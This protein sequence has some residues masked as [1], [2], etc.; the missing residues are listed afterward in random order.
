MDG[1]NAEG[2]VVIVGGSGFIGRY[3]VQELAR[4]GVRMRIVARNVPVAQFVK[5]LGGLGQIDIVARDVRDP[6]SLAVAMRGATAAVNLVGILDGTPAQFDAVHARGAG[7]VAHAARAAGAD[8]F[9]QMSA[10]GADAASPAAYARSKAAGEVAVR[11]AFPSATVL[12]PS[13]V[14]G[15]EDAFLNRFAGM[16]RSMPF[17][18][19]VV[20]GRTRFQP[21]YVGDIAQAVAAALTDPATFGGHTYELGGP[22]VYSFRELLA[23][24]VREVRADKPLVDVPDAVAALMARMSGALPG[25][26]M[27]QDQWL[28]LQS[29]NVAHGDG[30][31]AFGI[32]ATPMEAIAPAYLE[33]F[34]SAGRFHR[35]ATV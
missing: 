33:R 30:L 16:A 6:V 12:R 21:V 8:C 31:A 3:L 20:A 26:P 35:E 4:T 5:P 2:L 19:P 18:M 9:V 34:R 1:L 27:T 11:A 32:V 7:N 24:I 23:W 25:M 14:F 28:M 10:I 15:R 17:V 13:I 29:D 22:R